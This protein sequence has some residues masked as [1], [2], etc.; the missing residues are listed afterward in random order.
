VNAY[1]KLQNA[2]ATA[3]AGTEIWVAKGVYYPDEGTG[4]TD[5]VA[6][7]TF[8]LKDGVAIYGGFVGSETSRDQRNWT[9]NRTVLSGDLGQND[10]TDSETGMPRIA[11][12]NAYHVVRS[13]NVTSS[14]VLDGFSIVAGYTNVYSEPNGGGMSNNNSSPTL[15]NLTFSNNRASIGGGGMSNNNSS[16]RLSNVTFSNNI[17][18]YGGGMYNDRGSP[19]L[20]DVLFDNN[21]V[22]SEGGGMYNDHSNPTLTNVTF[23]NHYA[24]YGG[25]MYNNYT[26]NLTLSNVTFSSN[27]ASNGGG[28]YNDHSNPSLLGTF[29]TNNYASSNGGGM[30]NDYSSPTLTNGTFTS[31]RATNGGGVYNNNNS[32]PT[33]SNVTFT[34]NSATNGGGVYNN[35][36]TPTFSNV[37]LLYNSA[38]VSGGGLYSAGG[39]ISVIKVVNSLMYGNLAS[40]NTA[41]FQ[42]YGKVRTATS[43]IKLNKIFPL[44]AAS[45]VLAQITNPT[46]LQIGTDCIPAFDLAGMKRSNPCT[47]GAYEFTGQLAGSTTPAALQVAATLASPPLSWDTA[48]GRVTL[49]LHTGA[50]AQ[51][52]WI[53]YDSAVATAPAL[54]QFTL[55]AASDGTFEPLPDFAFT[56]PVTL[57]IPFTAT[58][59]LELRRFD[60]SA[61]VWTTDGVTTSGVM[62][63]TRSFTL[64]RVGE[65][66]LFPM[67][68]SVWIEARASSPVGLQTIPGGT[69]LT[70]EVTLHNAGQAI[71]S[72]VTVSDTLPLGV[73]FDAWVNRDTATFDGTRINWQPT[74]I[75]VGGSASISF[76][77]RASS[78]AAYQGQTI[79]NSAAYTVGSTSD[80]AQVAFSINGPPILTA[81]NMTTPINTPLTIMPLL[82]GISNPDG[83]PVTL[84]IGTP[85]HGSAT[86]YGDTIIYTPTVSFF[87]T[88]TFTYTVHD[89][90]FSASSE[91]QVRVANLAFP[92]VAQT[93]DSR[94]I[95][96]GQTL[97]YTLSLMNGTEAAVQQGT[98]TTTL[99]ISLTFGTWLTQDTATLTG[100]TITW[101][102]SEV[103]TNTTKTISFT[104]VVAKAAEGTRITNTAQFTAANADPSSDTVTLDVITPWRM[105]VPMMMM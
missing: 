57:T 92:N 60:A 78:A 64:S 103:L 91:V 87:G 77:V 68:T 72:G 21:N 5:N 80:S 52:T 55:S 62:A 27:K 96:P 37:S 12:M 44:V 56:T 1:P 66:G 82:L 83:S 31:N 59:A 70:Y 26:S 16:P 58:A 86:L 8:T 89:G 14:T 25:G 84:S 95:M 42:I 4:Q 102:Q 94:S 65:Y 28:M 50:I 67:P 43:V 81:I 34:N 18:S 2:L 15:T 71:A 46:G 9:T 39:S 38:I 101:K 88:D 36:G 105:Y 90:T 23:R 85:Q 19:M 63:T 100:R 10:T 48:A 11:G 3:S 22:S 97:T 69:L 79:T 104:V 41:S 29:F 24:N 93:V 17:A 40:L 13:T 7:S 6:Y 30:C 47:V 33:L 74:G 35:S 76:T 99:P 32:S 73:T 20:L 53:F 49:D 45:S 75:A 98:I 54:M 51:P 61:G